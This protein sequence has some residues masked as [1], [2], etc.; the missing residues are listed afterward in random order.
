MS[1]GAVRIL[2]TGV[3]ICLSCTANAANAGTRLVTDASRCLAA[4]GFLPH[5]EVSKLTL[6]YFLDAKSYPGQR[7]LYIVEYPNSSRREGFVFTSFLKRRAGRRVFDIQNNARF[8][9]SKNGYH[10]V[11]FVDPPLGG[12]W[13]QDHLALAIRVIEKRP[14]IAVPEQDLVGSNSTNICEAYTDQQ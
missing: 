11:T 13:T 9:F 1:V 5:S 6:G 10:G 7:M 12:N 14:T 3:A 4:K 8:E 2:L